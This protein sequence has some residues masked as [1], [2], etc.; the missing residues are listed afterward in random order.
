MVLK[1]SVLADCGA[2]SVTVPAVPQKIALLPAAHG[3]L[4]DPLYQREPDV[5][6]VPLPPRPAPVVRL[7]FPALVSLSQ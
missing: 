4:L 2:A 6:Q 5:S 7:L 1:L 3:T